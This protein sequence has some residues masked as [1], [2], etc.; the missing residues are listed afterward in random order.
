MHDYE[1]PFRTSVPYEMPMTSIGLNGKVRVEAIYA[2]DT[3]GY[4]VTTLLNI[5]VVAG[6]VQRRTGKV[7]GGG[8]LNAGSYNL[9]RWLRTRQIRHLS[10]KQRSL[11]IINKGRAR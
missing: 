8:A 10:W 1:L 9:M 5:R 7:I 2:L 4:P 3:T 6:W 11:I